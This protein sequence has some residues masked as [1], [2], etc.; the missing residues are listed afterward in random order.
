MCLACSLAEGESLLWTVGLC[1]P[2]VKGKDIRDETE[3]KG[4]M[5]VTAMLLPTRLPLL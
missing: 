3:L 2:L 1:K 5:V 4:T